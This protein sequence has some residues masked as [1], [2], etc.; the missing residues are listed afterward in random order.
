MKAVIEKKN[1]EIENLKLALKDMKEELKLSK[2]KYND[3]I[4]KQRQLQQDYDN[5]NKEYISVKTE[6]EN[7]K[8]YLEEQKSN[9]IILKKEVNELKK[10]IK[11]LNEE[12]KEAS[13]IKIKNNILNSDRQKVKEKRIYL[14]N[15]NNENMPLKKNLNK[16]QFNNNS[17]KNNYFI[18]YKNMDND[19]NYSEFKSNKSN[20]N[21]SRYSDTE[22]K[23]IYNNEDDYSDEDDYIYKAGIN[24]KKKLFNSVDNNQLTNSH[25]IKNNKNNMNSIKPLDNINYISYIN[26]EENSD[27]NLKNK[28]IK[29]KEQGNKILKKNKDKIIEC[30]LDKIKELIDNKDYQNIEKELKILKKDKEKLENELLKMPDPPI[31]LNN[32]K[33]KKE[34][35]DSI[36]KIEKDINYINSLLKNTDTH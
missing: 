36:N 20:Y 9:E 28:N 3:F 12:L 4:S 18:E 10:I 31:K 24:Y 27:K 34:I 30:H 13:E 16:N 15:N 17:D 26:R 25:H 11:K 6:K 22:E 7:M 19:D 23:I 8:L 2:N 21:K 14:D 5:L 1:N 35:N 29:E 33:N 32:I